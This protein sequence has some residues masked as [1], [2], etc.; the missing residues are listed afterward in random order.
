MPHLRLEYSKNIG[1]T[2]DHLNALFPRLH[3]VLVNQANAELFRCQSRAI[4]SENFLEHDIKCLACEKD[5]GCPW[6]RQDFSPFQCR[7]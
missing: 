3:E 1:I 6:I 2:R 4:C 7:L 5:P